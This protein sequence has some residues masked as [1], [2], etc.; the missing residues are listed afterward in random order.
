VYIAI[1]HTY[2][3]EQTNKTKKKKKL[4]KKGIHD[5]NLESCNN[6]A[7]PLRSD[8]RSRSRFHLAVCISLGGDCDR[9]SGEHAFFFRRRQKDLSMI[10]NTISTL[11]S[12]HI[13]HICHLPRITIYFFPPLVFFLLAFTRTSLNGQ[14]DI[15]F[16]YGFIYKS[17][18]LRLFINAI[19]MV[20]I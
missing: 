13:Q 20:A 3:K 8:L 5:A 4:H 6:S 18:F 16:F 14:S 15:Y 12:K 17:V 11:R 9:C 10:V 1:S 7:V 2:Y 19:F